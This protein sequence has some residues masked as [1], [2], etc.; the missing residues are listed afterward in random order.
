MRISTHGR[1]R[2]TKGISKI[3][4][5]TIL[6][7]LFPVKSSADSAQKAIFNAYHACALAYQD[8]GNPTEYLTTS[9]F[10]FSKAWKNHFIR[11]GQSR[12][13]F[14][15]DINLVVNFN[16]KYLGGRYK[17]CRME[18]IRGSAFVSL[19]NSEIVRALT[20]QGFSVS[21]QGNGRYSYSKG[22]LTGSARIV[23]KRGSTP[24]T[25]VSLLRK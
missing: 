7:L 24:V 11:L 3:L 2:P 15:H 25:S 4:V 18:I 23:V 5:F 10:K 20:K 9:G 22:G 6:V 17:G 12:T 14:K 16:P 8:Q 1:D 13:L 19:L 21:P